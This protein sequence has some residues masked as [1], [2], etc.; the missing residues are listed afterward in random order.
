GVPPPTNTVETGR[1]GSPASRSTRAESSTSRSAVVAYD[2]WLAPPPS[3]EAVYVLK[4]QYPHRTEQ[5]GTC[6]YTPK[7]RR[8]VGPDVPSGDD[9][10]DPATHAGSEPSGGTGSPSG[11]AGLT[12]S[13]CPWRPCRPRRRRRA[14][15]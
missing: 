10:P 14:R 6:R 11:S 2:A 7:P 5:N 13:T 15:R 3:S 1:S 9:G 8:A 12:S 4:S